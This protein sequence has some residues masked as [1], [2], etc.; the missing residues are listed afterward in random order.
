TV[1]ATI[2]GWRLLISLEGQLCCFGPLVL[3][4]PLFVFGHGLLRSREL[5]LEFCVLRKRGE[6]IERGQY[7]K[8]HKSYTHRVDRVDRASGEILVTAESDAPIHGNAPGLAVRQ[9]CRRTCCTSTANSSRDEIAPE[10]RTARSMERC[11][12]TQRA[13]YW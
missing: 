13:E 5:L 9:R 12:L 7:N 3:E 4:K 1:P 2:L 10:S 11:H 8:A 6:S